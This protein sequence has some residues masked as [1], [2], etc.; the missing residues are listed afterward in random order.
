MMNPLLEL[1]LS[2]ARQGLL[3]K[4][5]SCVEL[6]QAYL[7]Q[8]NATQS[9]NA[10]ITSTPDIALDSAQRSDRRLASGQAGMLEGIPVAVKDAYC[11]K[12]AFI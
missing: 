4:K 8:M 1:T 7:D 6:V 10:F 3:E 11:T 9:L 5:F 2:Q 12:G